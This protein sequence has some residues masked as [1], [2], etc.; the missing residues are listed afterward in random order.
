[1][2]PIGAGLDVQ[3][4]SSWS[5]DGKWIVVGGLSSQGQG[6]FKIPLD[7][8]EI[9]RLVSGMAVNRRLVA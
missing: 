7:G 2:Q 4:A 9:V 8:G 3:G 1:M 6:L 5:P